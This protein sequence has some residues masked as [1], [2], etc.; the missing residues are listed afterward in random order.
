MKTTYYTKSQDD[1][2]LNEKRGL[3]NVKIKM[4]EM[5]ELSDQYFKVAMIKTLQ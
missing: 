3:I 2:K 5:L 1:L 4:I